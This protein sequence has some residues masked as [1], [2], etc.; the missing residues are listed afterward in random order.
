[1]RHDIYRTAIVWDGLREPVQVV[2]RRVQLPVEELVLD[3]QGPEAVEQLVALGGGW[4]DLN[5]APLIRVRIAADPGS[6]RWLALLHIHQMVRDH[7]TQE[8]LLREVRAFLT[9]HGTSLPEPLPF[10]DFVAQARLG[11]PREEHE[12]HFAELLGDVTESTAPFGLLNVHGDG[13]AAERGQIHVDQDLA[14]RVRAV[15]RGL[16]ASAATVFHLAWARVLA[17]VSGRDDVVFG[18]V[19]FGRMNSGAGADRVQGPFINALPVRVR[20]DATSATDA[21][22]GIRHQLAELLAHEH[23]P[24]AVAQRASGIESGSPLFTSLFNYRHHQLSAQEA[25]HGLEGIS[26]L[27]IRERTNYPLMVAVDDFGTGFNLTVDAAGG[28]DPAMVC[29]LLRTAAENLVAALEAETPVPLSA[30]D[31]LDGVERGRLL[32]GWNDTGVSVAE[33]T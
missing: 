3:P 4:M 10:R 6:G 31:V 12:R 15:A 30:V 22:T 18:T 29:A 26:T 8:A 32:E 1:D 19:L 2:A 28:I 21:L 11:V 9:G 25:D 14:D 33:V 13:A 20:V 5:R 7:T 23:A 27:L 16:G 17:A 24:L